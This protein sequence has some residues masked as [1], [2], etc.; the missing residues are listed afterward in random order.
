[1]L[2]K[3]MLFSQDQCFLF[4]TSRCIVSWLHN[5]IS[6]FSLLLTCLTSVNSRSPARAECCSM[7]FGRSFHTSSQQLA[8]WSA[9]TRTSVISGSV[10]MARITVGRRRL[11]SLCIYQDTMSHAHTPAILLVVKTRSFTSYGLPYGIG[12]AIIFSCCG[13][14]L[15]SIYQSFF[16]SP[17]LSGRRLDVYHTSTHGVALV[18]I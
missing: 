6:V 7:S 9:F 16:S 15:L 10:H 17:N 8:L 11:R 4:V 12:Q 1:M 2:C 5:W 13:F 3:E 18:R 14:C